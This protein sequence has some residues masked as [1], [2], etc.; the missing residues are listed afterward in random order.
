MPSRGLSVSTPKSSNSW[1]PLLYSRRRFRRPPPC[2]QPI[3]RCGVAHPV[4]VPSAV[5][6]E[7]RR[8]RSGWSWSARRSRRDRLPLRSRRATGRSPGRCSCSPASS[9]SRFCRGWSTW[10]WLDV[11]IVG[12]RVPDV[13]RRVDRHVREIVIEISR[14]RRFG[15][16]GDGV[17]RSRYGLRRRRRLGRPRCCLSTPDESRARR[18][19]DRRRNSPRLLGQVAVIDDDVPR[20]RWTSPCGPFRGSPARSRCTSGRRCPNAAHRCHWWKSSW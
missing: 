9:T 4:V 5:L 16:A 8:T 11:V 14:G 2:G 7:V 13:S 3:S 15:A 17:A 19:P 6:G 1:R 18:T 20:A 10:P 12:P